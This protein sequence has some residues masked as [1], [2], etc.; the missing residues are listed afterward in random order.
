ML[1][2]E[3]V[4]WAGRSAGGCRTWVGSGRSQFLQ[5]VPLSMVVVHVDRFSL[6]AAMGNWVCHFDDQLP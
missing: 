4:Y 2:S 1:S 3:V 5:K 6:T